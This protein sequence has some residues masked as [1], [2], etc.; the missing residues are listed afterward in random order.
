MRKAGFDPNKRDDYDAFM[1][2]VNNDEG[3][4]V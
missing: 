3:I 4:T 2:I 1:K